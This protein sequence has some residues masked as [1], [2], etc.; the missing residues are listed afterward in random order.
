MIRQSFTRFRDY[1]LAS[2]LGI[3]LV[4]FAL[5]FVSVRFVAEYNAKSEA[6][7]DFRASSGNFKTL[8]KLE[9]EKLEANAKTAAGDFAFVTLVG[10]K[11][12][13]SIRSSFPTYLR[14]T[15]AD[16][17][18]IVD[19][20]Y[21]V[22]ATN[23][24]DEQLEPQLQL[25]VRS[26]AASG[27]GSGVIKLKDP[28]EVVVIP[29]KA[30]RLIGYFVVG[31]RISQEL[32]RELADVSQVMV[33]LLKEDKG[34]QRSLLAQSHPDIKTDVNNIRQETGK[35]FT[36]QTQEDELIS[37][38]S[39]YA[40]DGTTKFLLQ[41]SMTQEMS[42]L[43]LLNQGLLGIFSLSLVLIFFV[44]LR[45][46]HGISA[47]VE[48]LGKMSTQIAGGDFSSRVQVERKDEL[49]QL[50]NDL[51]K[52]AKDLEVYVG[53]TVEKARMESELETARIVQTNLLPS[54]GHSEGGVI[55]EGMCQSAS[56][57]GGDFWF[58]QKLGDQIL[59]W[60]ADVTGHGV[61]AAIVTANLRAMTSYVSALDDVNL[62]DIVATLNNSI[63]DCTHGDLTVTLFVMAVN[64]KTRAYRYVNA[65]HNAPMIFSSEIEKRHNVKS[66]HKVS[67]GRLG[68]ARGLEYKEYTGELPKDPLL[69]F[70]TDG[71]VE[72]LNPKEEMFGEMRM[73]R[74]VHKSWTAGGTPSDCL[75]SLWKKGLA[76][77]DGR[78]LDDDVTIMTSQL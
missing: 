76:F 38:L 26:F 56:E 35:V 60:V 46:A 71:I 22:Q 55:I 66:L 13:K 40:E 52:M 49:G 51:N 16:F 27:M 58:Y 53:E 73:V 63:H 24:S 8:L 39:N 30:P 14:K 34:G 41:K 47:P 18:A 21:K 31:F 29:I 78:A 59:Y 45:L 65:C 69:L 9:N 10:T 64:R 77:A 43:A 62:P 32:I 6:E 15:G 33:S 67:G 7:K 57:C 11:D 37:Y 4:V 74:T 48:K 3:F 28:F 2:F 44:S 36:I 42:K 54:M 68:E 19:L 25:V 5:V 20:E 72:L 1:L 70:Y 50:S 17:L 23:L 12:Y 75:H 61:G